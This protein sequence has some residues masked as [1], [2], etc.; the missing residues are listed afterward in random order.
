VSNG[1]QSKRLNSWKEIA[2]YLGRDVRTA[3]RWEKEKGL[4]VRRLPGGKRQSVFAFAEE[5]DAWLKQLGEPEGLGATPVVAPSDSGLPTDE[6]RTGA[7]FAVPAAKWIM[8]AGLFA[9]LAWLAWSFFKVSNPLS[10]SP[11]EAVPPREIIFNAPSGALR[12]SRTEI[13]TGIQT[14][15]FLPVDLN[16]DGAFDLVFSSDL[17][18][19]IGVLLGKGDGS[20]QPAQILAGRCAGVESFTLADFNHDGHLDIAAACFAG[21]EVVVHWGKGDGTF[22][23]RTEIPVPGGPRYLA[24][25]DLNEDGWPDLVVSSYGEGAIYVL[26]N[27]AG[28]LASQPLSRFEGA[29][30]VALADLNGD[31]HLDLVASLRIQGTYGLAIFWG[32]GDGTF[33]PDRNMPKWSENSNIP[34]GTIYVND[35]NG[36]GWM[37]I[38]YSVWNRSVIAVLGLGRGEF[39]KP[40]A[41]PGTEQSGGLRTFGIGDLDLDGKLDILVADNRVGMLSL[42][43]GNGDGSFAAPILVPVGKAVYYFPVIV[44]INRDGRPDILLNSYFDKRLELLTANWEK[45]SSR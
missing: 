16:G 45:S 31:R 14:Y 17:G 35:L 25:G 4:P 37:D 40:V 3:V 34:A 43:R 11:L 24:A 28:Q 33:R 5:I 6:T 44:D 2:D 10:P 13:D 29:A 8:A 41:L 27:Q 23:Q 32:K 15:R 22:P 9:A 39:S 26:M 20:F 38:S 18:D 36:D 1:T 19:V 21:N 7:T 30:F 12:F 42:Y